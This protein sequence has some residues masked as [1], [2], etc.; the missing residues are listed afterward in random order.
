MGRYRKKKY[1]KNNSSSIKKIVKS[2]LQKTVETNKVVSY[3]GW[4][5]I[6]AFHGGQ[7]LLYSLTGGTHLGLADAQNPQAYQDKTLFVML[8][9]DES[10][11]TLAG[12]SQASQGGLACRNDGTGTIEADAIGGVHSL[13]GRQ[14]F[15][16]KFYFSM[17][18]NNGSTAVDTP[19]NCF[20]RLVIFETRRPLGQDNLSQ[21]IFLQNHGTLQMAP[22]VAVGNYPVFAN[23]FMNRDIVK[24]VYLDKI[25]TMNGNAGATGSMR[26]FKSQVHINKKARWS[27]YYPTRTPASTDQK[28]VYQGP[29]IYMLAFVS[30][31]G[32]YNASP[33]SIVP[34]RSPVISMSSV[35]TYQDD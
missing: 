30:Q 28:L 15:L 9:S 25:I 17:L 13:E 33:V 34:D 29:F 2:E 4:S 20:I 21:Q 3:L 35:L 1:S 32:V 26:H 16:K 7:Q 19:T 14:C 24:K 6:G 12:V 11:G 18:L 23:A 22:S 8:P 27:Y 10:T 31:G 5:R